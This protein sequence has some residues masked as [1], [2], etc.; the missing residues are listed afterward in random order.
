MDPKALYTSPFTDVAP[1]GPEQVLSIERTDQLIDV[2][3][4]INISAGEEVA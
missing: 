4:R 1:S 3:D 2:I